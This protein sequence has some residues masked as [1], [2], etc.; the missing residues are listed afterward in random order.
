MSLQETLTDSMDVVNVRWLQGLSPKISGNLA[1]MMS[2]MH[3][4]VNE[5][6]FHSAV[7]RLSFAVLVLDRGEQRAVG[8][9]SDK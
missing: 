5:D 7:P 1:A 9:T 6:I 8:E 2:G 3:G 4:H